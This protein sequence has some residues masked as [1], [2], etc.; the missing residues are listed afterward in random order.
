[1]NGWMCSRLLMMPHFKFSITYVS[2]VEFQKEADYL[3][4]GFSI[5]DKASFGD[6]TLLFVRGQLRNVQS[7]KRHV[8]NCH[9]AHYSFCFAMSF[10]SSLLSFALKSLKC[11]HCKTNLA[12]TNL[13]SNLK[14][15]VLHKQLDFLLQFSF[16]CRFPSGCKIKFGQNDLKQCI[17]LEAQGY[18]FKISTSSQ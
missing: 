2:Q 4:L 5:T 11:F 18:S 7:F 12:V 9:S 8:P 15:L 16:G 3:L 1:M 14:I 13:S 10:L 6:F 17:Y